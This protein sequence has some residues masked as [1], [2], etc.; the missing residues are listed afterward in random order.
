[1]ILDSYF[2]N[3]KTVVLTVKSKNKKKT[4]Y[5]YSD[6]A[7]PFVKKYKFIKGFENG[8]IDLYSIK[9]NKISSSLLKIY[10]FRLKEL[11]AL[12]KLLTLASL[13]GIADIL[14]GEGVGFDEFEMKFEN[15]K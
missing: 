9:E 2:P 6:F 11:P 1:M 5:F 8:K 10:D 12:T 7:K 3:N 4:T 14:S 15:K 13:K